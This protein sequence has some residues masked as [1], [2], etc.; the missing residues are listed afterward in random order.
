MDYT[1]LNPFAF[2][3][4]LPEYQYLYDG[5]LEQ[6]RNQDFVLEIGNNDTKNERIPI[7]EKKEKSSTDRAKKLAKK[8]VPGTFTVAIGTSMILTSSPG[9]L[10]QLTGSDVVVSG[11]KGNIIKTIPHAKAI[12][13]SI[14][15]LT[16][17]TAVTYFIDKTGIAPSIFGGILAKAVE[18]TIKNLTKGQPIKEALTDD[19]PKCNQET[20]VNTI[21][22]EEDDQEWKTP[23]WGFKAVIIGSVGAATLTGYAV[24]QIFKKPPSIVSV[25]LSNTLTKTIATGLRS[26][27]II[28]EIIGGA[29]II[30][31]GIAIDVLFPQLPVKAFPLMGLFG[32]QLI[33]DTLQQ[34]L[35]GKLGKRNWVMLESGKKNASGDLETGAINP[36]NKSTPSLAARVCIVGLA[37]LALISSGLFAPNQDSTTKF[38]LTAAL[39]SSVS[40]MFTKAF[41]GKD[42]GKDKLKEENKKEIEIA[43]KAK[44]EEMKSKDS[45]ET[46][47]EV[48]KLV[49]QMK[50]EQS[51]R[52]EH[53]LVASARNSTLR[54]M[55]YAVIYGI[56]KG[57]DA[58]MKKESIA[59]MVSN[60]GIKMVTSKEI[61][62]WAGYNFKALGKGLK[63]I[64]AKLMNWAKSTANEKEEVSWM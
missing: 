25:Y 18:K 10:T 60:F 30:G 16:A 55:F 38:I 3:Q 33:S 63:S 24:P 26:L 44:R 5:F 34:Y 12:L 7:S 49:K 59:P 51:E 40:T 52:E 22:D 14:P 32:Y 57:V 4:S 9:A 64:S 37:G 35:M 54:C 45:A 31:S 2:G 28:P 23:S 46:E 50:K 61:K 8:L 36:Q 39:T 15:V 17:V 43:V 56:S 48:K 13:I 42:K 29:G 1:T 11:L 58:K 27:P 19:L 6:G 21:D 47:K 53:Q 41:I 62:E 20:S